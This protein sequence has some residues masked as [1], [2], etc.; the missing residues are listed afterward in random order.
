MG[1]KKNVERMDFGGEFTS[2][3]LWLGGVLVAAR[4]L[5]VCI[6]GFPF[7]QLQRSFAWLYFTD[8]AL[9][10]GFAWV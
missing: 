3:L 2:L 7:I 5:P 8:V 6:Y 10:M 4:R 9:P 1:C